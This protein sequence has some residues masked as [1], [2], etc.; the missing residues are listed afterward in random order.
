MTAPVA[1]ATLFPD[2]DGVDE[3]TTRSLLDH[4]LT[5]S[6]LYKSGD[7]YKA[8]LDFTIRMRNFAPFNAMLIDIQ[9]PGIRFAA[10]ALDW[11]MRFKRRPKQ[12][13]RP[14]LILWP[15]GPV[16]L[17]YDIDDTEGEDLPDSVMHAFTAKGPVKDSDISRFFGMMAKRRFRVRCLTAVT[18]K[19]VQSGWSISP[20][21]PLNTVITEWR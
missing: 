9:K 15:F 19:P 7:E 21:S 5:E 16:A 4:L 2:A 8:L 18:V 13:A 17:V 14:L 6:K 10:S 3:K 12:D 1:Q 11:E 20:R